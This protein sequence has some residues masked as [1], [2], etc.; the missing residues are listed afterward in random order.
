MVDL[1]LKF[2]PPQVMAQLALENL[3]WKPWN[4]ILAYLANVK[5]LEMHLR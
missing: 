5:N 1:G 4:I 3:H 2:T